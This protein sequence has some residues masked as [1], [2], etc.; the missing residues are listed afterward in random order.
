MANENHNIRN[1]TWNVKGW[2]TVMYV[3]SGEENLQV[4]LMVAA[5]VTNTPFTVSPYWRQDN[6]PLPEHMNY[7]NQFCDDTTIQHFMWG[8]SS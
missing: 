3:G 1:I 8:D 6:N 2:K 5:L 4:K 7:N